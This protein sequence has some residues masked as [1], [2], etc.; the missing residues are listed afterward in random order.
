MF[1]RKG[2]IVLKRRFLLICILIVAL[3]VLSPAAL[4]QMSFEDCVRLHIIAENDTDRAQALK[5]RVRDSMIG[6]V[7]ALFEDCENDAQAWDIARENIAF[8]EVWAKEA[9]NENGY[10]GTV[11]ACAQMSFFPDREWE[12]MTVPAGEY[13][14]V[15]VVIG[16]GSGQNWWCV[17]YPSVCM[18]EGYEPGMKVEF[19]SSLARWIKN[20][21]GGNAD[22]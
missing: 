1:V 14:T 11:T 13:R 20:L 17:L 15:R 7:Q 19:Y 18:P 5:I 22:E 9:A 10:E 6:K 4:A 12:G 16:E 21:F 3:T 8:I 2:G